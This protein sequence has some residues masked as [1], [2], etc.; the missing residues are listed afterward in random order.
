MEKMACWILFPERQNYLLYDAMI[1]FHIQK[2][3]SIPLG[4]VDF[5][6][7]L[8]QRFAERDGMYFLPDQVNKYDKKRI[9]MEVSGQLSLFVM[10]E[11]TAI[12][13]LYSEL[14]TS[15]TYQ[16]LQPKFMQEMHRVQH[17]KEIELVDLL[18]ENFL[19]D[20]EGNGIYRT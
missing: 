5:Y 19:Q 16:Q 6:K 2:G 3:A 17:E 1:A 12:Q 11:K 9:R 7:G 8:Q 13:W 14:E 18:K 15:Q 20:E 10:D 4:A